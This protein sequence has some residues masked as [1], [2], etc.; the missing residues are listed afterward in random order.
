[1]PTEVQCL[2]IDDSL[3]TTVPLIIAEIYITDIYER[4]SVI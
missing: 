1:M 4:I 3:S 2:H